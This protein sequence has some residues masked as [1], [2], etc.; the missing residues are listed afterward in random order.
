MHVTSYHWMKSQVYVPMTA[1]S[2]C[3]I[4]IWNAMNLSLMIQGEGLF[5]LGF[6]TKTE[7]DNYAGFNLCNN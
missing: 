7:E 5:P 3:S 2:T 1:K 6:E 4:S